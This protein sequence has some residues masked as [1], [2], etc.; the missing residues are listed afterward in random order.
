MIPSPSLGIMTSWEHEEDWVD[1][2]VE[3]NDVGNVGV[4]QE[5]LDEWKQL[6]GDG[7]LDE[8]VEKLKPHIQGLFQM[9]L[10]VDV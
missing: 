10:G 1:P 7:S 9:Y 2:E 6:A 8:R 4:D 3:Y 5:K